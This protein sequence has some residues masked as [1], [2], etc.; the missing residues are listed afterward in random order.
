MASLFGGQHEQSPFVSANTTK[1][2]ESLINDSK[3]K[4]ARKR[5]NLTSL[6]KDLSPG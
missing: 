1:A 3:L 2:R 6:C 5:P 4:A